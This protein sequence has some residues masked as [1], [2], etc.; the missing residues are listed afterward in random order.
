[1]KAMEL[2]CQETVACYD[3]LSFPTTDKGPM[4]Q[5]LRI[6]EMF[7][8]VQRRVIA[9]GQQLEEALGMVTRA[10]PRNADRSEE[11]RVGKD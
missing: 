10:F 1:M 6:Q 5:I 7:K 4:A 3:L 8:A 9:A 11:R 2:I